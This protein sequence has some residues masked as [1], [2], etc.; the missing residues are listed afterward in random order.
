MRPHGP[1]LRLNSHRRGLDRRWH[2]GWLGLRC[3][4]LL[5]A[6]GRDSQQVQVEPALLD[7]QQL[8]QFPTLRRP[9]LRLLDGV[10][11]PSAVQ[12]VDVDPAD[13]IRVAPA[14]LGLEVENNRPEVPCFDH[15]EQLSRR[16]RLYGERA[17]RNRSLRFGVTSEGYGIEARSSMTKAERHR[18]QFAGRFRRN[19]FGWRSQPLIQRVQEAVS[20]IRRVRRTAP[21]GA[22]LFLEI[23]SGEFSLL[24]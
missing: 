5:L 12:H 19:A 13:R 21:E 11:D 23:Q 22:V 10:A 15:R 2:L 9:G 4:L 17:G 1:C 16:D 8:E 14:A 7:G 6:L 24:G 3:H 20:E 18:W